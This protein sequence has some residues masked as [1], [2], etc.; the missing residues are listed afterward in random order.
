MMKSKFILCIAAELL[1][2]VSLFLFSC[3]G[4]PPAEPGYIEGIDVLASTIAEKTIAILPGTE[5]VTLAVY[6]FTV[7]GKP[8]SISDYLI[9]GVT[10]EIA[11]R[12]GDNLT[13][14]SR[15]GLD[16][17]ME[18][19]SLM[20][21][22]LVSEDTQ[23]NLGQ[24]LGADMVLTGY[25]TPLK[26]YNKINIQCIKVGTGEVI[27]GFQ[28]NYRVENEFQQDSVNRVILPGNAVSRV[29]G[30]TT[31]TTILDDFEGPVTRVPFFHY[32]E[33]WGELFAGKHAGISAGEGAVTLVFEA[34][35]DS[36]ELLRKW[37]DS[38][39]NFYAGFKTKHMIRADYGFSVDLKPQGFSQVYLFVSQQ[40]QDGDRVFG[41][42]VTLNPGEWNHLKIPF[43]V[44]KDYSYT[45][46]IEENKPLILSFG[47]PF[48][49]NYELFYFRNSEKISGKLSVDNIGFF[50]LDTE[51][52]EN[53]VATFDDEVYRTV[54][55]VSIDNSSLYVDY[56]GS[57]EGILKI[58]EGVQSLSMAVR[59]TE[60]G[61]AGT[62]LD[63]KGSL[64][65]NGK[66]E[67][68]IGIDQPVMVNLVLNM[69]KSFS[70]NHSLSFLVKA[71]FCTSGYIQIN[72]SGSDLSFGA[73]FF[74][75]SG[76]GQVE[77]PFS[78]LIS[79]E[80]PMED[81]SPLSD[82]LWMSLSFPVEPEMLKEA[83]AS[84]SLDFNASI[85]QILLGD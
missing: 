84:G 59:R 14:V 37:N 38:D 1:T 47:V 58:N 81:T 33:S 5:P 21:T 51:D 63:M 15:Q 50:T 62:Y 12:G 39:L 67:E 10:T 41:V 28:L 2:A 66:I 60:N 65:I 73:P 11:N 43:N 25:I 48:G 55:A 56:S 26:D 31:T 7:D 42:P 61:P 75:H 20:L 69:G 8:G 27:G 74:V 78:E 35:L 70:G 30:V 24:L 44:L 68:F 3:A 71:D 77:I 85:D 80:G 17:I 82:K 49:K 32:E 34:E 29:K 52:D 79:D 64:G 18:E 57:G 36:G 13:M 40:F 4:T 23:V 72:D 6:Y 53:V 9:N 83:V 16:R 45:G 54:P 22:D 19:H 76:W 46:P